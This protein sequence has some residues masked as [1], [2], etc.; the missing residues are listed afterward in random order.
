MIIELDKIYCQDC[1]EFMSQVPSDF[2]DLVVTDPPYNSK[3]VDWDNKNDIWQLKWLVEARRIMKDGASFY[4]FFAPLNMYHVEGWIRENLTL[5][6]I[7]VWHHANLYGSGLSY[8]KDRYKST[9]DVVF[10]AVKGAH[11]KHGKNVS[12]TAYIETGRGF[13]VMIYPQPR[14]LLHKAQKPLELIKKFIICSSCEGNIVVDPFVGAGTT[15]LAC[16]QVGRR[17]LCA[18]NNQEFVDIANTRLSNINNLKIIDKQIWVE[19][20]GRKRGEK[21]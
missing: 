6:N 5:K 17:F 11:A 14:P 18:D 4:M 20:R 13:D 10:Y 8:G 7:I 16:R 3:A 9:W 19:R 1:L 2:V 15:A 12:S 21:I